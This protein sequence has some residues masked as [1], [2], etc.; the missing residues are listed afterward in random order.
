LS[1][2]T[3][4]FYKRVSSEDNWD[5]LKFFIDNNLMGEWS[6]KVPWS[7]EAYYINVGNHNLKWTY[8]K[9]SSVDSCEDATYIDFIALPTIEM[10]L[11]IVA[12]ESALQYIAAYPNPCTDMLYININAQKQGNYSLQL[13]NQLGQSMNISAKGELTAGSNYVSLN[14]SS[15][16]SGIYYLQVKTEKSV[17][18]IKITVIR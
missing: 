17:Q 7:R 15:L 8:V 2:D 6:G 5:F 13:N 12:S 11:N 18:T 9:D 3:I 16:P 4:S 10:P 14:T 1:S